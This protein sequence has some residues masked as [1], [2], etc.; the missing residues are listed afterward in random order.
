MS[1]VS[2]IAFMLLGWAQSPAAIATI[3]KVGDQVITTR[4]LQIN[5]FLNEVENP[6][7]QYLEKRDP[8]R[9][10]TWEYLIFQE[11]KTVLDQG[12]SETDVQSYLNQFKK[13]SE[14][15][16]LW[17]TMQV[18]DKAL[19]DSIRRKLIVKRLV[20]LKM[21]ENLVAID[22]ESVESYYTLNRVQLGNRPLADVREKIIKG[23]KE[24]KMQERFKDWMGAITRTH[25]VVY[26]SGVKIQ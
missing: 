24:Q 26:F 15:D 17:K 2:L 12:I 20:N 13:K 3:A 21:P 14:G 7:G 6:L 16:R 22:E 23:L 1:F 5:Q 19:K 9:E 4:D 25:G 11:S 18:G 8:L 10:I